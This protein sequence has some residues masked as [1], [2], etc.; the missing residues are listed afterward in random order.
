MKRTVKANITWIPTELGGR[1]TVMPVGMRYCPI[2][3]FSSEQ[4]S[5]SLW[6]AE[7]FNTYIN[8]RESVAD[9]TYLVD[10]A[11]FHLLESGRA[12]SL[13]EGQRIVAEG[14]IQ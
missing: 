4:T 14:V 9:V 7:M 1:K 3:V 5:E 2:I 10:S 11:P 8:G 13:Y 12:F 6:C